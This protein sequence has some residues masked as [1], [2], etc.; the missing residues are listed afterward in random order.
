MKQSITTPAL[1]LCL[2]GAVVYSVMSLNAEPDFARASNFTS[3][4]ASE[5]TSSLGYPHESIDKH[6]AVK[7]SGEVTVS[8]TSRSGQSLSSTTGL[9]IRLK[10]VGIRSKNEPLALIES[11][12]L[13]EEF[14][15]G[16]LLFNWP[17]QLIEISDSFVVVGYESE[18]YSFNLIGP[19]LLSKKNE[20]LEP[21]PMQMTA[22]QIGTRPK[23]IE[24]IVTLIPTDFIADGMLASVGMNPQLFKQI[25]LQEDDVIKKINGKQITNQEDFAELQRTIQYADTLV[26]EIERKG[27]P[28]TLYLDIPS[29]ELTISR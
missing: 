20:E 25:G 27:R 1:L 24:H 2:L 6:P 10:V 23:I 4:D 5:P 15:I 7:Q 3:S 12:G 19:N 28:L 18:E 21:D 11:Q 16:E 29:E 17:I 14:M 22:Q 8:R 9:P 26:F 13:V